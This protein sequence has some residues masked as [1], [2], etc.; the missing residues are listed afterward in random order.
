MFG[1][2]NFKMHLK[3]HFDY[4]IQIIANVY[5]TNLN[6]AIQKAIIYHIVWKKTF[7][8][9]NLYYYPKLNNQNLPIKL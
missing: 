4:T 1:L 2:Y 8:L 5:K 6:Y 3:M 7:K 9:V